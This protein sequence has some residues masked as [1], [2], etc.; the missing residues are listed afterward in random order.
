LSIGNNKNIVTS[1]TAMMRAKVVP[2]PISTKVSD[3]ETLPEKPGVYILKNSE[4]RPV[5]VGKASSIKSRILAHLHPR[6]DDPIGQ[7]LKDQIKS[8]DYIFTQ[9]PVEALILENVLIKKHKPRYNIRLKDDKSYPYVKITVSEPYP[10]VIVTR[11]VEEGDGSRYYGPY[12]NVR[13]AKLTV[14]YLRRMFQIRACSLPL[15]GV[16]KF[17]ACIDHSIGLCKA[18]CIFAVSREEYLQDVKKFQMYLEGKLVQ[19]SK[20][21][22]DEMWKSAEKQDFERAARL[23]DEIRS[24]ETTAL[25]QR[26]VFPRSAGGKEK[27][28][29]DVLAI[30]RGEGG[31]VAAVVFQVRGGAVVGREK[32]ILEGASSSSQSSSPSQ[33]DSE[34]ISAL[35]SQ[36]YGA[37]ISGARASN[38]G[39]DDDNDVGGSS[40]EER[41]PSEIVVPCEIRESEEISSL[42]GS[43]KRGNKE[44]K[45]GEG[46]GGGVRITIG[47]NSPENR[48]LLK[49][50]QENALLVLKEEGSK[51]EF[52]RRERLRA[53]KDLKEALELSKLPRRIECFDVSNIRG[54]EAVG[55]MTVFVNGFPERSEYR[56]FKIKTVEGID[57]YAMMAEMIGRR[58][59]R[60]LSKRDGEGGVRRSGRRFSKGIPDLVLIDGGRGHLKAAIDQMHRDGIFGIPTVSIAKEEELVFTP[61]RANPIRLGEDSEALH[62]LQHIRDEAHRFGITYHRKL[63]ARKASSSVLDNIPGIGEKRKRNLLAH[64]GS[65]EALKRSSREEIEQVGGISKKL[66]QTILDSLSVSQSRAL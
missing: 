5:Y 45:E 18:P 3:F 48:R 32:F 28:D 6:I 50:A 25:K 34:I 49:L 66:A 30:A 65:I 57:D 55:A 53:L 7:S 21:M 2:Q 20:E 19:L 14:K 46:K 64:F 17:K 24:L 8:V 26:I 31:I 35:I 38:A 54:S 60:L 11:R 61:K 44:E 37:P 63:R 12:G 40:F 16:K 41:I 47:T 1:P 10:R 27:R 29:K 52:R 43:L 36:Y 42:L 33:G 39:G 58:F 56:K 9:T 4:G 15:D 59:R 22:Y 23:R 13:A 62:I 51:S